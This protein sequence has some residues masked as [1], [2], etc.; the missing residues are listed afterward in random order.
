MP[1]NNA[2]QEKLF[3]KILIVRADY[4]KDI[5]F[6]LT[7]GVFIALSQLLFKKTQLQNE[8]YYKAIE[9]YY[10][11]V[12]LIDNIKNE[13]KEEKDIDIDICTT[14]GCLEIPQIIAKVHKDYDI[15]IALGCVI[16]GQTTHYETVCNETN[17]A[18][19]DISLSS[20]CV[21]TNAIINAENYHQAK[22]RSREFKAKKHSS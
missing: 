7:C 22:Q 9:R 4:Y 12:S 10:S 18:I 14:A 5:T 21:I 11:E 19:M 2:V 6:E 17:R 15:I 8:S 20:D 16:R 1:T 13:I 3:K